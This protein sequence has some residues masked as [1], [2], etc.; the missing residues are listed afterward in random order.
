MVLTYSPFIHS[1]TTHIFYKQFVF[2]V[3]S[4]NFSL[5]PFLFLDILENLK[6]FYFFEN[7]RCSKIAESKYDSL[8][9]D[10][11]F[12]TEVYNKPFRQDVTTKSD[13]DDD[14]DDD[15]DELLLRSGWQMKS[16]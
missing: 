9:P 4:Q 6:L 8:C 15:D 12:F 2:C 13:D 5:R 11:H 1:V 10:T 14:D 3:F 16:V 7:N